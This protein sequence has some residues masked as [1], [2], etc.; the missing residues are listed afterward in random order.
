[1]PRSGNMDMGLFG[2]DVEERLASVAQ[3]NISANLMPVLDKKGQWTGEFYDRRLGTP[4]K[5]PDP[6]RLAAHISFIR[7][8]YP[9][10]QPRVGEKLPGDFD[11]IDPWTSESFGESVLATA[12]LA[13]QA[14]L[15]GELER[16]AEKALGIGDQQANL[17]GLIP[18]KMRQFQPN[19]AEQVVA[20]IGSFL[21]PADAALMYFSGGSSAVGRVAAGGAKLFANPVLRGIAQRAIKSGAVLG[22]YEGVRG[23]FHGY[24]DTDD[25][26]GEAIK[27]AGHGFLMG[28]ALGGVGGSVAARLEKAPKIIRVGSELTSEAAVLGVTPAMIEGRPITKEDLI[29][30]AGFVA[31]MKTI[32]YIG[33]MPKRALERRLLA[34]RMKD[35]DNWTEDMVVDE[36]WSVYREQAG[37]RYSKGLIERFESAKQGSDATVQ[38]GTLGNMFLDKAARK[39]WGD[40]LDT[41]VYV[42]KEPPPRSPGEGRVAAGWLAPDSRGRLSIWLNAEIATKEV[43]YTLLH[44]ATHARQAAEGLKYVGEKGA[45]LAEAEAEARNFSLQFGLDVPVREYP[46][47]RLQNVQRRRELERREAELKAEIKKAPKGRKPFLRAKLRRLQ[48]ERQMAEGPIVEAPAGPAEPPLHQPGAARVVVRGKKARSGKPGSSAGINFWTGQKTQEAKSDQTPSGREKIAQAAATKAWERKLD[49]AKPGEAV[50][51]DK[52]SDAPKRAAESIRESTPGKVEGYRVLTWGETPESHPVF[53][54]REGVLLGSK[55]AKTGGVT[56]EVLQILDLHGSA[57]AKVG[58]VLRALAQGKREGK[59][60]YLSAKAEGQLGAESIARLQGEGIL[61]EKRFSGKL[62]VLKEGEAG[63]VPFRSKKRD[64]ETRDMFGGGREMPR[65][66]LRSIGKKEKEKP[67]AKEPWYRGE[68]QV[69]ATTGDRFYSASKNVAGDFGRVKEIT[70]TERPRNPLVVESKDALAQRIGYKGDPM[71]EPKGASPRFDQLAK[72]Y[73]QKRGHDGIIYENG[74]FG[75][76]ELHAFGR[77]DLAKQVARNPE[78]EAVAQKNNATYKGMPEAPKGKPPYYN[79][80]DNKTGS[81]FLVRDLSEVPAKVKAMREAFD[82][83]V[84]FR[85]TPQGRDK[86]V[87]TGERIM[88]G[89]L[90]VLGKDKD[91]ALRRWEAVKTIPQLVYQLKN[92]FVKYAE[93]KEGAR[94]ILAADSDAAILAADWIR[95][96]NTAALDMVKPRSFK[97]SKNKQ[98][99]ERWFDDPPPAI[100]RVMDYIWENYIHKIDPTIGRIK[101]RYIPHMLKDEYRT[102]VLDDLK[103]IMRNL[104]KAR[105]EGRIGGKQADAEKYILER[106]AESREGT[107]R[108]IQFVASK[109]REVRSYEDLLSRLGKQLMDENTLGPSYLKHRKFEFPLD[110]YERDVR[111]VLPRYVMAVSK[112]VAEHKH[113]G[114][115]SDRYGK[116]NKLIMGLQGKDANAAKGLHRAVAMWSGAYEREHGLRGGAKTL[117]DWFTAMQVATKIGMGGATILNVFQPFIS[118]VPYAGVWNSV[119]GVYRAIG[120]A[121]YR[122]QWLKRS[123]V[124]LRM[125]VQSLEAMT[126]FRPSGRMGAF[127]DF[128]TKASGFQSVNK[129]LLYASAATLDATIS[130]WHRVAQGKGYRAN[131]ARERL[132][133]WDI[134]HTKPLASQEKEILKAM[135]RFATDSQLQRN[136]LNEPW[137]LND[138]R[139]RW[140]FLFKRFGLRQFGFMKDMLTKEVFERKNPAPL[141]RLMAGGFLGGAVATIAIN[142]IKTFLSGEEHYKPDE[143]LYKQLIDN[144]AR[145]GALGF[146]GDIM[147]VS[148]VS[149]L[150]GAVSFAV[151]PVA[152]SDAIKFGEGLNRFLEDWERYGDGFLATAR[153]AHRLADPFGT[154]PRA[155]AKRIQTRPQKDRRMNFLRTQELTK[156]RRLLLSGDGEIAGN[157]VAQ[158]NKAHPDHAIE[159]QDVSSAGMLDWA[160]RQART[161]AE[162]KGLRDT[163]EFREAE[164]QRLKELRNK[165]K[166]IRYGGFRQR[167]F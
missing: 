159:Y 45:A 122:E 162:A 123:G 17:F 148:R 78:A 2:G 42:T 108:L 92:T 145:A 46:E 147:G 39:I 35:R 9:D 8:N 157:R 65:G 150:S 44:E 130:N 62:R 144:L 82:K 151:T 91:I 153:G 71:A 7:R 74:T 131:L 109:Y 105:E 58:L 51:I 161:Y 50:S 89:M 31:G 36:V 43:P 72:D 135:H 121:Q 119:R 25:P 15:T 97:D 30:A 3:Q 128:V 154:W 110:M 54:N 164:Q 77:P 16:G 26:M 5:Q 85:A 103:K 53:G 34:E 87:K 1:M 138:P 102:M 100:Q 41:P 107:Q 56:T 101:D 116:I 13:Y 117:V 115:G 6:G 68:D 55:K 29:N 136:V 124:D 47:F 114:D 140:L 28:M 86:A 94:R 63:D 125:D 141:L 106:L 84:A 120:D 104:E 112:W 66:K 142:E 52:P 64:T 137:A 160:E 143:K 10:W 166:D 57:E 158:W 49:G 127:A 23:A 152:V 90:R 113:F 20:G 48:A 83:G 111:V 40:I 99:A 163:P 96:L 33:S 19:M 139:L 132:K 70:A 98:I 129:W 60:V 165:L 80:T 12:A 27:G 24:L 67:A 126:G 95:K 118:F 79:F 4:E 38:I 146:V 93:G 21:M 22:T 73:A 75:E 81:D 59:N 37:T 76:R 11:P 133:D 32:G 134:D 156:V 14:S 149:D 88:R 155:L 18:E 61:S 69:N 167:A